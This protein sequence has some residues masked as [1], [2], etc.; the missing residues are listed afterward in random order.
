MSIVEIS[1]ER[2][3]LDG[4]DRQ[5]A[6]VWEDRRAVPCTIQ[7]RQPPALAIASAASAAA[8]VGCSS[9]D[10][11]G[12]RPF[13]PGLALRGRL[14]A[15]ARLTMQRLYPGSGWTVFSRRSRTPR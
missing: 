7:Q 14:R 1:L 12:P 11:A 9:R 15:G 10:S 3:G 13:L 4:I 2:S 6:G 5:D 8:P